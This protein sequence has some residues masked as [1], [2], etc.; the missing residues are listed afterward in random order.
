M[1]CGYKSFM[2]KN[3]NL[4]INEGELIGIIGPNGSGKTTLLKAMTKI[5]KLVNGSI[6]LFGK[7]IYDYSDKSFSQKVAVVSQNIESD[8]IKVEDFVLMGRYCHFKSMQ[9]FESDRDIDIAHKYL[10]LT[11]TFKLKDKNLNEISGGER[12]LVSIAKAL[13]QETKILFLDEPI[14]HLDIA[15]QIRVMELVKSL[16]KDYGYTI[17]MILHDLNLAIEYCERLVILNNGEIYKSG[18]PDDIIDFKTIEDVY[19]TIVIVEKNPINNKP[20][21]F[22]VSE[23]TINKYKDTPKNNQEI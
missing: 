7:N 13:T 23:D 20:Y 9:F 4:E 3:I 22:L 18:K 6:T 15:H 16:N 1:E 19:K 12:Q 2:L 10:K 8:Y 21:V 5:I 11:D 14:S 17:V